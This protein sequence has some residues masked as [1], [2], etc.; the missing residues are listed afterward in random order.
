MALPT[1]GFS[2]RKI[3][4]FS[5]TTALTSVRISELPSLALVWPSNWASVSFTEM[6]QHSPSRQSSPEILSSSFKI[7]IFLP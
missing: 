2:S 5:L 7:F 6:T 4:S 3:S 1:A